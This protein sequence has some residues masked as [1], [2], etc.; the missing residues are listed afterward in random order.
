MGKNTF[1][2]HLAEY[3]TQYTHTED[4]SSTIKPQDLW[5]RWLNMAENAASL[6]IT[7]GGGGVCR[8]V[9]MRPL[10]VSQSPGGW[11][12]AGEGATPDLLH[13]RPRHNFHWI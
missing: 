11:A 3:L 6:F 8:R 9:V 4:I 10:P 7:G 12:G 5:S 13:P 2:T 1:S